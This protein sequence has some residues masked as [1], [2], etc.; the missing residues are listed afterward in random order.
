M[1]PKIICITPIRNE[2]W[3]LEVFLKSASI[4]ADH[5][6]IADQNSSDRGRD[7]ICRY[8]K[9]TIIENN[10][11][12]P[13]E[14]ERQQMLLNAAREISGPKIIMAIDADEI[15]S[16]EAL[17][18]NTWNTIFS[19][20]AGTILK[21]QWAT[22]FP[23][24]NRYWTGYHLPYGYVDDGVQHTNSNF[25][26]GT[27][28]PTPQ[29][30]P[31]YEVTEFKVIHFQYMNPERNV[32]RQRWYQCLELDNP[33][34]AQDAIDIYR[35]YHIEKRLS[36]ER[37]FD[38]PDFWIT[39][40]KKIGIDILKTYS[41]EKY[42]YDDEVMKLFDKYG[43]YHYKK[44]D[45]WHNEFKKKDPRSIFDKA[46]HLWLRK[47]QPHYFAKARKVDNV[48]RRLFHY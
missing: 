3:I 24:S 2:A 40:Y 32:R 47:S 44:L 34:I 20:P 12:I 26:H 7:I 37:F 9:A 16:P 30:H 41:E 4:W 38:I 14:P 35:K 17:T 27:R 46:I 23:N 11:S 28:V 18:P 36:S 31:V 19:Q 15:L 13:N 48:I 10:S 22:L 5:I 21:F 25:F 33:S 43:Y 39:H 45:I 6:I 29:G 1:I 42:W 8:P